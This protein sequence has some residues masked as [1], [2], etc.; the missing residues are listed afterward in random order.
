MFVSSNAFEYIYIGTVLVSHH[1]ASGL[2]GK[3]RARRQP[4]EQRLVGIDLVVQRQRAKHRIEVRRS[5]ETTVSVQ[6]GLIS[7]RPRSIARLLRADSQISAANVD[8][9][10]ET[11]TTTTVSPS[12]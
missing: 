7:N 2:R 1:R 6:R 9:D 12:W 3:S 10:E 5:N 11:T 8:D 4:V